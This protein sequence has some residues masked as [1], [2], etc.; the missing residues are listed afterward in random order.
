MKRDPSKWKPKLSEQDHKRQDFKKM[1]IMPMSI[2]KVSLRTTT[3]ATFDC[4]AMA[5]GK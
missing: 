3:G 4:S 5:L 2:L 1:T